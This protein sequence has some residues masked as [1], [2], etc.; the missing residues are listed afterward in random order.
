MKAIFKRLI[1]VS[2]MS[3][4]LVKVTAN[5]VKEVKAETTY[6]FTKVEENLS[7]W[8]GEYLIVYETGSLAFNGALT[9]LDAAN[10]YEEVVI[11]GKSIVANGTFSF[12]IEKNGEGYSIKSASGYYIFNS[13]N[14]NALKS[15][16]SIP[17]N[18]NSIS[19]NQS[20]VDVIA[21][22]SHLRFNSSSNQMRFRYYKSGTY[23]DQEAI[24][25]YKKEV[26]FAD[27]TATLHYNDGTTEKGKITSVDGKFTAPE[28]PTR[29][30]Y[31]FDGWYTDNVTF[32]NLF[33]FENTFATENIELYAK[34]VDEKD[35]YLQTTSFALGFDYSLNSGIINDASEVT[36]GL[37][38]ISAVVGDK[39]T[40]ATNTLV[41]S[42]SNHVLSVNETTEDSTSIL[43]H[44]TDLFY[45]NKVNDKYTIQTLNGEYLTYGDNNSQDL[46]LEIEKTNNSEWTI[47]NNTITTAP[48]TISIKKSDSHLL[49][50]NTYKGRN[51]FGVCQ[52]TYSDWYNL[53]LTKIDASTS[54]YAL[55]FGTE[56]TTENYAKLGEVKS[57]GVLVAPTA[58]LGDVTFKDLCSTAA[59]LSTLIELT[60][61]LN[62]TNAK[63]QTT[64]TGYSFGGLLQNVPE[65]QIHT[66]VS[67]ACY[68]VNAAGEVFFAEQKDMSIVGAATYYAEHAAELGLNETETTL[69]N[70]L[71][72][73]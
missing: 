11:D 37:Y 49:G 38:T 28:T 54:N 70:V 17:S 65:T 68:V 12:F 51:E 56:I 39:Y 24:Q 4:G 61:A 47:E 18:N 14:N 1:L 62:I 64:E 20:D 71:K 2:L 46:T 13:S 67:A 25:L 45:I 57:Y 26:V 55:R 9:K 59:E 21:S 50:Y 60:K 10:N 34:W 66:S 32:E 30:G 27:Y 23:T 42:G 40:V 48:G 29:T 22:S 16:T 58:N 69:V 35:T 5:E 53:E 36:N 19:Y 63:M 44:Y 15:S 31:V 72:G 6:T 41:Q 33:D 43:N 52:S 73:M 3:L 7:D 8:T